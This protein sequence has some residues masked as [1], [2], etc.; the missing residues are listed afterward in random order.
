MK[1]YLLLLLCLVVGLYADAQKTYIQC[2]KLINGIS[3]NARSSVTVIVEGK[4]IVAIK[5]GYVTGDPSDNVI[6]LK[7]KTVLPGFIDCHVHLEMQFSKTSFADGFRETDADIAFQSAV[8]A[9]RTLMAGFTS[10]RDLG[11]TGVNISLRNAI[12][13]GLTDGP[14]ILTAGRAISAS[15]GHMDPSVRIAQ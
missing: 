11:G 3:N 1:R 15:G 5:D 9:R 2:G 14:N 10:V 12:N 6:D 7:N 8:Y 4:K 13:R